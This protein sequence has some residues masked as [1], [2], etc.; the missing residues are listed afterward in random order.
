MSAESL[1]RRMR[2]N[3]FL[4]FSKKG[5]CMNEIITTIENRR[6]VR[7]YKPEPIQDDMLQSIIRSGLNAPSAA[8]QQ[9]WHLTVIRT[10]EIIDRLSDDIKQT[11]RGSPEKHNQAYGNSSTFHVFYNA[12]VVILV[13]GD[14]SSY[15]P[16]A[17]CSAAIQNM[18]LAAESFGIGSCWIGLAAMHFTDTSKNGD[19]GIPATHKLYFAV[20]FGYPEGRKPLAPARRE[21]TVNFL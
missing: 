10:R 17:D 14:E 2:L 15:L 3:L 13:S 8:N 4:S 21:G 5:D 7:V 6:S 9:S 18:L 11:L 19:F 16:M 12:P 20:T 1:C